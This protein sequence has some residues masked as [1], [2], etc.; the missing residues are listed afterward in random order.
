P[1]PQPISPAYATQMQVMVNSLND[2]PL[3]SNR[4]NGSK[5]IGVL[6]GNSMM[7]Q[8]FPTHKNYS[9]PQLSNLYGMVLPLLKRGVPVEMVHMENTGYAETLK[10]IKTLIMS[11]S[12]MKPVS[13]DVHQHI[14][15]WV[16]SG[17]VLIYFGRDD[18]P[19]QQVREW[20]N[21]NGNSY[22]TPSTHLFEL[23]GIKPEAGKEQYSYGNGKVYIVRKDPKELVLEEGQD[24]EFIELVKNAYEQDAKAGKFETKNYFYLERGPYDI[25]A[26]MDENSD[27]TSLKINGPVIDLFNPELPVLTEKVVRPGEEAYLYDLSRIKDKSQPKVLCAA[28]RVYDEKLNNS[29]YSFNTKSPSGTWNVMRIILPAKPITVSVTNMDHKELTDIKTSWDPGTNTYLLQFTNDCNGI[30]VELKW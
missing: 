8:R 13:A 30:N 18:D 11:Y 24:N 14:A 22:K 23:M 20:W 17:G 16:K 25:A 4:I 9:D 10:N 19:F 7:F 1:A 2:M 15:E 28:S 6:L 26:V 21:T 29:N 12:N 5:G 3:A 27:T